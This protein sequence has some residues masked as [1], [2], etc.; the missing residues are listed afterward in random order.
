MQTEGMGAHAEADARDAS[1]R[2]T[3]PHAAG[4]TH[5]RVPIVL[6]PGFLGPS[7]DDEDH[8][9]RRRVFQYWGEAQALGSP[10]SQVICVWPGGLS[11][12]H[13][14][15]C[16]IFYQIKGGVVDYGE[17]HSLQFGHARFGRKY[18]G[19]YTSWSRDFPIHVVGHS[20]GGSTVR[21]LQVLILDYAFRFCLY[22][23]AGD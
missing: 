17:D 1:R 7:R 2:D 8:D 18:R 4:P 20:L 15:A 14:R 23:F 9:E 11:S 16:E 22:G 10:E 13:D 19:S 3:H 5:C 6:V 21:M 12:L